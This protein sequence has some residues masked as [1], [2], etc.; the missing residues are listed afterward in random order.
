MIRAAAL[1]LMASPAMADATLSWGGTGCTLAL[2]T[3]AAH[4][5]EVTCV[6]VQTSGASYTQGEMTING[7][8]VGLTVLHGP[9]DIPDKFTI[10]PP[11]GYIAVP[12]VLVLDE[13]TSGVV[14][15]YQF[16]G[17]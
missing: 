1:C 14:L 13:D 4:V 12:N 8:G 10:S 7:L 17:M 2:V 6:N 5:A 11:E 15:I 3:G 9:G 16:L